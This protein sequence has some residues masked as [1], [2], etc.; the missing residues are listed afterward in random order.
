[1]FT[2]SSRFVR[3]FKIGDNINHNLETLRLLYALCDEDRA[4][5]VLLRKPIIIIL[6][7]AAEAMLYDFLLRISSKEHMSTLSPETVG[8]LRTK[9]YSRL[10]HFVAVARAHDLFDADDEF[11]DQ[12]DELRKL[13][14]RVH[15]QNEKNHFER[16]ERAAFREDRQREAERVLEYI[17][18]HLSLKHPRSSTTHGYVA[19]FEFPWEEHWDLA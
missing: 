4:K 8:T 6:V 18:K 16:D 15:I 14:N 12:L 3:V 17:A 7:S 2:V 1:V 9:Q 11:Y 5:R 10:T 19:D 13:R